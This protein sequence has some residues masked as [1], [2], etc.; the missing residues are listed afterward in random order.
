MESTYLHVRDRQEV[1]RSAHIRKIENTNGIIILT[2]VDEKILMD[3]TRFIQLSLEKIIRTLRFIKN[4][5]TNVEG[6][7]M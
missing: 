7:V 6:Q 5:I 4:I 3:F 1:I 2:L